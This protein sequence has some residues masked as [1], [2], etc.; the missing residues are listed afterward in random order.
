MTPKERAIEVVDAVQ[1]MVYDFGLGVFEVIPLAKAA[2]A[3]VAADAVACGL[4]R[5]C[6]TLSF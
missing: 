1:S 4:W 5:Q 2:E 6:L 3:V